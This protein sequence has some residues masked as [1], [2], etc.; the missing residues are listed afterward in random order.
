MPHRTET[1]ERVVIVGGGFAGLSIAARL[2]QAGLPVTL[3]EASTLGFEASTRNQGWLHSGALFARQDAALARLC[4]ASLQQTIRF[5]PQCIEPGHDGMYYILSRPDSLP[6]EWTAAW[7]AAEIPFHTVT[8]EDVA[9]A[10]PGINLNE[11]QHVFRLPDRSFRPD[12]LLSQLAAA[13]R[14]AGAEVRT[15]TTVMRLLCDGGNVHGVIT[16]AGEEIHGALVVLAAGTMSSGDLAEMHA[17]TAGGQNC[18]TRV[19]LKT[20]LVAVQPDVG[21]MP[22]CV[23][24]RGGFNHLP[25]CRTSVFG[26]DHWYAVCDPANV[27]EEPHEIARIWDEVR[28]FFPDFDRH[29]CTSGREWAGTTVQAMHVD[30]VVPGHAPLPAVIDHRQGCPTLENLLSVYPGRATLWPHL[31]EET[32]K[33]VLDRLVSRSMHV[34]QPPWG[35]NR[36][37]EVNV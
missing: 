27:S 18:I 11:V 22:F 17:S 15:G 13:A 23:L 6:A 19:I 12:E 30:Q 1:S 4:Y 37:H 5:C 32:R 36:R 33:I 7:D 26:S 31:A 8:R 28:R 16:G 10:L 3:L 21:R 35:V 20:H 24:D 25:H 14:N 34:A 9:A 29:K 2:A